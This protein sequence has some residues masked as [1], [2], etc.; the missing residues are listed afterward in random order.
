[1]YSNGGKEE[2]TGFFSDMPIVSQKPK[3][4]YHILKRMMEVRQVQMKKR[5]K[6]S[7]I[8]LLVFSPKKT[9]LMFI[10][11]TKDK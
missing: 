3:L 6:F 1:M 4:E 10:I 11:L 5:Q 2:S 8:P 7:T 9:L